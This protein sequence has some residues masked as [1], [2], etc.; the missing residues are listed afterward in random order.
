MVE[1]ELE[2]AASLNDD[3]S[4]QKMCVRQSPVS[5]QAFSAVLGDHP[6]HPPFAR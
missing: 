3:A 4:E 6:K 2:G 5:R 1:A